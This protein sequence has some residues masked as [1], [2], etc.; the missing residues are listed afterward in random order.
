MFV[1]R[2][3]DLKIPNSILQGCDLKTYKFKVITLCWCSW[4]HGSGYLPLSK[5]KPMKLLKGDKYC[6]FEDS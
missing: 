2:Q 3:G 6:T 4:A 1:Q 5:F